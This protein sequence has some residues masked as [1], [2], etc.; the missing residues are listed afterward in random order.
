MTDDPK[1]K[2]KPKVDKPP[3]KGHTSG[4]SERPG[5][6]RGARI[7]HRPILQGDTNG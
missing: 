3:V 5:F 2:P 6:Y 7:K 4:F 1:P